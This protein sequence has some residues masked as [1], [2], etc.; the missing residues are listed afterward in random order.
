MVVPDETLDVVAAEVVGPDLLGPGIEPPAAHVEAA[1]VIGDPADRP[2]GRERVVAW[3]PLPVE[4]DLRR[5]E[6]SRVVQRSVDPDGSR[7]ALDG[8]GRRPRHLADNL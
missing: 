5:A 2:D 6:P 4:R 3:C 8:E 1:L 7:R